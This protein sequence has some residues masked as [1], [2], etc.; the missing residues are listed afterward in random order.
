MASAG[1]PEVTSRAR[2]SGQPGPPSSCADWAGYC[3]PSLLAADGSL[4]DSTGHYPAAEMALI[5]AHC[6]ASCGVIDPFPTGGAAGCS[7]TD[8]HTGAKDKD[9]YN[10]ATYT[11]LAER[12]AAANTMMTT[13]GRTRCAAPAAAAR[14]CTRR[15]RPRLTASTRTTWRR[16]SRRAWPSAT[17]SAAAASP[18][19]RTT[20]ATPAPPG[21]ARRPGARSRWTRGRTRWAAGARRTTMAAATSRTTTRR[22]RPR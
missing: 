5:Y 14:R 11:Q 7:D 22:R 4:T 8:I 21:N 10:C 16:R 13:S 18:S 19:R 2:S 17:R 1:R 20:R 3:H 9:G 6:P 12:I 15:R